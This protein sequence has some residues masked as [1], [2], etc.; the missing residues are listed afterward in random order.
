MPEEPE[1]QEKQAASAQIDLLD[2]YAELGEDEPHPASDA[3][4]PEEKAVKTAPEG[5]SEAEKETAPEPTI[6]SLQAELAISQTESKKF[7]RAQQAHYEEN[8]RLKRRNV[9]EDR[10]DALE[11]DAVDREELEEYEIEEPPDPVVDP[12]GSAAFEAKRA[13]EAAERV[14]RKFDEK[15]VEDKRV[16]ELNAIHTFSFQQH[17]TFV[18]AHP[19]YND[20]A[21]V[22]LDA[23][24]RPLRA[25]KISEA[26]IAKRMQGLSDNLVQVAYDER[27]NE[28][29]QSANQRM[30]D[31]AKDLGYVPPNGQPD[32]VKAQEKTATPAPTKIQKDAA[33]VKETTTLAATPGSAGSQQ[34]TSSI[35]SILKAAE[36]DDE[37]GMK[38]QAAQDYVVE[39]VRN[40]L[41]RAA[42]DDDALE[43]IATGLITQVK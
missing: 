9:L 8:K 15:T 17:E 36:I 22:V 3:D 39:N 27:N 42:T 20:A 19:D 35:K 38:F 29:S 10:M 18:A 14:E 25:M 41:P 31:M 34:N 21:A 7:Q 11:A 40:Q 6:E 12:A 16:A 13:V 24:L 23:W 26:E 28:G 32:E 5:E 4:K 2:P 1:V 30:Y 43:A 37:D 33:R